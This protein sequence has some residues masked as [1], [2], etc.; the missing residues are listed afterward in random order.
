[1]P[2]QEQFWHKQSLPSLFALAFGAAL[3][4]FGREENPATTLPAMA[5]EANKVVAEGE[6][7]AEERAHALGCAGDDEGDQVEVDQA[8]STH[9]EF[10]ARI[11]NMPLMKTTEN[12]TSQIFT[13][14]RLLSG[15][16][17]WLQH[18]S[19]PREA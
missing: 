6:A 10:A 5:S 9:M 8:N 12:G 17:S 3:P 4:G 14:G 7:T 15:C 19:G 2:Y 11:R 1:M 16:P 18:W 13:L